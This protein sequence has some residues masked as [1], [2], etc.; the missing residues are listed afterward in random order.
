MRAPVSWPS[1]DGGGDRTYIVSPKTL[2]A[3]LRALDR[4]GYHPVTGQA[5]VAHVALGKRLP[6]EPVL[7]T[8]DDASAEGAQTDN[9]DRLRQ[10][11]AE[12]R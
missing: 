9:R 3:Q 5:L 4:A 6:R 7:L 1:R 11:G 8:F 12:G 10:L 2:A